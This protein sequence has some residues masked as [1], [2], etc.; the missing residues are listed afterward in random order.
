MNRRGAPVIGITADLTEAKRDEN[1][2]HREATHFLPTATAARLK[3]PA[4]WR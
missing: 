1:G 3:T 2:A 4:G